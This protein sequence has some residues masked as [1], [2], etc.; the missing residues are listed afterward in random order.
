MA[1]ET[2]HSRLTSLALGALG[3][4]FGDI[5]TSPLYAVRECFHGMHAVALTQD[6]VLGVLSLIFWSLLMVVGVKYVSFILRAD[7]HGEGGIFALLALLPQRGSPGDD[8]GAKA[9]TAIIL[10]AVFGSALL[11]GDG[12]ITPAVSVLSA[13]EGLSVATTALE[14]AVLPVTCVILV[15]LFL[16]QKHGT[17]RIGALFGPIMI[18]WF[19]AL[20]AL[21]LAHIWDAPHILLAVNPLHALCFFRDN[22]LHGMVV[23]GS[24]VLCITGGEALYADMGHFGRRAIRLSWNGLVLPALLLNYFGQGALL[25]ADPAAA[26]NPFFQ[27]VPDLLLYPLVALATVA[28]I[29]ASQAMISGAFSLTQQA[30]QL[31]YCP[32]MHIVHTS[33]QERGQ[34][35]IPLVNQALML[36]CLGLV[37]FFR[38]SSRLAGA[39]GIA[40]TATMTIT[41]IAYFLVITRTWRWSP[42][43]AGL[44]L[45]LF[46]VFDASYLGANLLKLADGGWIT[47][48]IALAISVLMSTWKRGRAELAA[49]SLATRLPIE[50]FIGD[51]GTFKPH[52]V[53]GTAVFMTLNDQGTPV[54]LLHHFKHNK[55][56]HEAVLLLT[57][58]SAQSPTVPESQRVQVAA[59]DH[60]FYRVVAQYGFMETPHVPDVLRLAEAQGVRADPA[61]TTFFLGRETILPSGRARMAE[62]RKRLFSFMSRNAGRPTTF[63]GIPPS[64]TVELG[65]MIEL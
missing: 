38:E 24:V 57:V 29:I 35:Y 20:A 63:F 12:V 45:A 27:M 53:P 47:I 54:T 36:G 11:Y 5:G 61:S 51:V 6:N 58:R 28:T 55:V 32:R 50:I 10:A 33:G 18:F 14:P 16:M 1:E 48:A 8:L 13:V 49:Q 39:Y 7:N 15:G 19:L 9:R 34:I 4:V 60:G 37:L 46:L 43:K 56:L 59:L 2:H 44:L 65:A 52:R 62:W 42:L 41:S 64:R 17:G 25:L 31:G 21:G 26:Q 40:V 22:G 23:L 3:V 30:I